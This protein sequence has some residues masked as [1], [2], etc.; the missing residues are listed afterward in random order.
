MA[1]IK[2]YTQQIRTAVYGEE[3]REAIADGIEQ[4]YDDVSGGVDKATR[5]A[6]QATAAATAATTAANNCYKMETS[7]IS[8]DDY[9]LVCTPALSS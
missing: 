7:Q 6:N 1:T 4:C 9:K 8:G 5:A 3:V 2:Q